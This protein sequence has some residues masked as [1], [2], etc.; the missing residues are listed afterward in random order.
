MRMHLSLLLT[1]SV[2]TSAAC[3]GDL[4]SFPERKPGLWEITQKHAQRNLPPQVQHICLDRATDALLYKF[5]TGTARQICSKLDVHRSGEL[6]EVQSACRLAESTLTSHSVYTYSGNTAY[7]EVISVHYDPPL[8][9]KTSDSQTLIDAKWMGACPADMKPGDMVT[10]PSQ[11][12]PVPL[13][14]NL[15]ALLGQGD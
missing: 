2:L 13:H 14:M 3:A 12:M 9:G 15:R 11:M 5:G 1:G 4:A 6:I 7:H 10:E 8:L